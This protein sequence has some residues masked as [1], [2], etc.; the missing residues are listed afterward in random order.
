MNRFTYPGSIVENA[1]SCEAKI[2]HRAQITHGAM[3][4]LEKIRTD[5]TISKALKIW[6]VNALVFPVFLYA[7][8]TWSVGKAEG[9][10]RK[11]NAL[12]IWCWQ[13]V[14]CASWTEKRTNISILRE[15]GVQKW[16]S[17]VVVSYML[18]YFGPLHL[19][20]NRKG[21]LYYKMD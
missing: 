4:H 13:R 15:V 7:S 11:V 21:M 5:S 9:E 18:K 14:L 16:L 12:E 20:N 1:G 10:M 6:L 8:Q 17:A 3:T 19:K 2:R